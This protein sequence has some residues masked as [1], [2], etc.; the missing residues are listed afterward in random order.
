M[1]N[2]IDWFLQADNN[3]VKLILDKVQKLKKCSYT[4]NI[5]VVFKNNIP[6][7]QIVKFTSVDVK[8][9]CSDNHIFDVIKNNAKAK[10]LCYIDLNTHIGNLTII[11][12]VLTY[13]SRLIFHPKYYTEK[14]DKEK[15]E[16]IIT[17]LNLSL[18]YNEELETY[19]DFPQFFVKEFLKKTLLLTKSRNN[20]E[21]IRSYFLGLFSCGKFK[22][23]YYKSHNL[24]IE[25]DHY[26]THDVLNNFCFIRHVLNTPV[27][28]YD[29]RHLTLYSKDKNTGFN[30]SVTK[31]K[32]NLF[33]LLRKD[34]AILKK[35]Q[36]WSQSEMSYDIRKYELDKEGNISEIDDKEYD[37]IKCKFKF[38]D[39]SYYSIKRCDVSF[40]KPGFEDGK[41]IEGTEFV[42]SGC[43]W[44]CAYFS[45]LRNYDVKY[46]YNPKNDSYKCVYKKIDA[47]VAICR[48]NLTKKEI[49]FMYYLDYQNQHEV[50]KNWCI[51]KNKTDF[52]TIHTWN[53]FSLSKS[54]KL[55]S[56][57]FTS[58]L[59]KYDMD[60]FEYY[61]MSS[62]A[63]NMG[64]YFVTL[65][66]KKVNWNEYRFYLAK[67]S[68]NNNK[69]IKSN[70]TQLNVPKKFHFFTS[71]L[72][73]S[74]NKIIVFGGRHDCH[75][76]YFTL[77]L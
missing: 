13:E 70:I 50:E 45:L 38:K 44:V 72:K 6:N 37:K 39:E 49:V 65:L 42:E 29:P 71:L 73:L 40:E 21:V 33:C 58:K 77:D 53:P 26:Y 1:E 19:Y 54:D 48:V 55:I 66:H 32:N 18:L 59:P 28:M 67:F 46:N 12:D 14:H 61:S 2:G 35:T 52:F 75:S 7:K 9:I 74:E 31:I 3:S 51:F 57:S 47:K 76:V 17:K 15:N 22:D 69:I 23:Y 30:P 41:I 62:S 36:A 56:T 8:V 16:N 34:S 25:C 24:M 11:E 60:H 68:V 63:I 64:N 20:E 43:T 10:F 5:Y 4:E 27:K